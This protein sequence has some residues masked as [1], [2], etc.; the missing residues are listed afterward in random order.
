MDLGFLS[1]QSVAFTVFVCSISKLHCQFPLEIEA[2]LRMAL[3]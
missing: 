3:G 1:E 2:E